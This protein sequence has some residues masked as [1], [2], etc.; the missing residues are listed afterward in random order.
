MPCYRKPKASVVVFDALEAVEPDERQRPARDP[1]TVQL[2]FP[3]HGRAAKG[4]QARRTA[5]PMG[6]P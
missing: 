6:T 3:G 2:V 4:Q 1:V 5:A